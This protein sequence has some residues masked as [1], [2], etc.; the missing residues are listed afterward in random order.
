MAVEEPVCQAGDKRVEEDALRI[1]QY[2]EGDT[3]ASAQQLASRLLHTVYMGTQNSSRSTEDRATRL[4]HQIGSYHINCKIDS[5]VE[6]MEFLFTLITGKEPHF[7]V[8]QSSKP[9]SGKQPVQ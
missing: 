1:G 8:R 4:A 3:V 7:R 5:I 2:K 9:I 6:S